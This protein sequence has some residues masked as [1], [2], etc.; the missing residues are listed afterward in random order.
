MPKAMDNYYRFLNHIVDIQI[1]DKSELVENKRCAQQRFTGSQF[2][3]YR[4]KARLQNNCLPEHFVTSET[5]EL[6][7]F[8]GKGTIV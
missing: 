6:R 4:K 1:S 7:F 8:I 3:R 2:I 5:K